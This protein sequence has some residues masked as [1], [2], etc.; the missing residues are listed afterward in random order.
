MRDIGKNIRAARVRRGMTQ[1]D[2]AERLHVS[3]QTVSNYETG[4]SRPDV[5]MLLA[6]AKE[7]EVDVQVLLYGEPIRPERRREICILAAGSAALAV[8]GMGLLRLEGWVRRFQGRFYVLGPNY[9]LRCLAVPAFWLLA[10]WLLLRAC[11][12]FLGVKLLPRRQAR[13]LRRAALACLVAWTVLEAPAVVE[14]VCEILY[15]LGREPGAESSYNGAVRLPAIW[16]RASVWGLYWLGT[17]FPAVFALPGGALWLS[18]GRPEERV[19][20]APGA[21]EKP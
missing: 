6:A 10:G 17:R 4:R 8:L 13:P 16:E 15:V 9:L 3:R 19:S 7:L 1:D 20:G 2:L 18:R 12:I 11:G 14:A 21:A 5:E